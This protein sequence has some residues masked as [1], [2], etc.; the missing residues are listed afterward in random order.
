MPLAALRE[1]P[2][3]LYKKGSIFENLIDRYYAG[4]GFHPRVI[5]R[6]D[7]AE[8]IKAMIGSGLGLSM[9]P[10]WTVEAEV[11]GGSLALIRQ[12]EPPIAAKIVLVTRRPKLPRARSRPSSR[13]RRADSGAGRNAKAAFEIMASRCYT[14]ASLRQGRSQ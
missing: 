1:E 6:F 10:M 12:Q 9:L 8:A 11:K 5:M 3:I 7:N 4:R 13:S 14:G 2:F